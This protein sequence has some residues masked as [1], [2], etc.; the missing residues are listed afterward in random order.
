LQENQ[1]S[2]IKPLEKCNQLTELSL[3]NNQI[4]D[5]KPLEKCNQ[6]T[7]L[8]LNNNHIKDLKPLEKCNQLTE[9]FLIKNQI[10]DIKPLEKC[11]QLIALGLDHNQVNN[12]NPLAKCNRLT[13]LAL[14]GNQISHLSLSSL[15]QWPRLHFL[16]LKN[17]PI[18]NIAPEILLGSLKTIR[19]YLESIENQEDQHY[20]NEAKLILVGVGE[21]GKT[22]LAKAISEDN[23]QFIEG[24]PT[25]QGIHIKD[26]VLPNCTKGA[27]TFDFTAHIWDFAGQEINYGT[28]QF[29]LTKNSVYVFLWDGRKGEENCKFDY[30]LQVIKLLSDDAPVF[31]VQNKTDIYQLEINQQN[32]KDRFANIVDFRKTSCKNGVG[33]EELRKSIKKEILALNHIGEIWNKNRVAVRQ[34]LE[35][36][37]DNYISYREYLQICEAQNVN[38]TDA[39]F[40]SQQLHDIGVILYFEDDFALQDTVV[41][42]PEWA[43][44][45]AYKL[46]DNA[47]ENS[48]IEEGRFHQNILIQLWD[49]PS[50]EGKHPFL[51]RLMERFELIFQLRGTHEYIIPELLPINAPA[52][53]QDIQPGESPA[54]HLRFEYHYDFMP[55]G[56]FSRF[57]CRIHE[58]I[59]QNLYW[60]YGVVLEHKNSLAKVLWNDTTTTKTIKVEAWGHEADRLLYLIRDELEFIHKKLNHPPLTEKIPCACNDCKKDKHPFLFDYETLLKYQK[61]R[62]SEITCNRTI[63][64]VSVNTLLNGILAFAREDMEDLLGL[65]N[66]YR[67]ADFFERLVYLKVQEGQIARL[68]KEYIHKEGGFQYTDRLKVW[69]LDYFEGRKKEF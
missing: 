56:V 16:L 42:K 67:V 2:D 34:I 4:S 55:K 36:K 31:V 54:K 7:L 17:N 69:V 44:K 61:K 3:S 60:K 68:R 1:I 29:F 51:L 45:A 41:L 13:L 10:V 14:R 63:E 8:S 11:D 46:L 30:W 53:V 12:L 57:I 37:K 21:V 38:A 62:R 65:I 20:L 43:T 6:L 27:K 66:E 26:W 52:Q 40:L 22:E 48:P 50:F 35:A 58:R 59:H 23:Y 47:K 15:N 18:Q 33:I 39:G 19:N 32:W 28:H 24:R 49:D 25:T 5:L 64:D 9:L